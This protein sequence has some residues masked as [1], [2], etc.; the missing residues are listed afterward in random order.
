[1]VKLAAVVPEAIPAHGRGQEH[2]PPG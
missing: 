1:V 2:C